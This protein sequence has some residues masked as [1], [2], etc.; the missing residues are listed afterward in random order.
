MMD[1]AAR[2]ATLRMLSNGMYVM[3]ARSSDRYGSATVTWLSQA[4]FNPPLIMAAVRGQSSVFQCLEQSGAVA[5]HILGIDQQETARKFF[6]HTEAEGRVIN[7]EPFIDGR[8]STPIL[9]KA[10]AYVECRVQR[11]VDVGGDHIVVILEV[12]EAVCREPVTPLTVRDSPWEYG[13]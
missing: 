12:I 9:E 6:R 7:G 4:S 5:V 10:P 3:T 1:T 2:R 13:G 8:L 11:I